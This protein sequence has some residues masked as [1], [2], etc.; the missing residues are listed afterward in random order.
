LDLCSDRDAHGK[1]VLSIAS[2]AARLAGRADPDAHSEHVQAAFLP[3][4]VS[5]QPGQPD[6]FQPGGGSARPR[7]APT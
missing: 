4:V 1:R 3:D 7:C 2:A 6:S 5:Y